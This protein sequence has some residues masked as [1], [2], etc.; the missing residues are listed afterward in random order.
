MNRRASDRRSIPFEHS[1]CVNGNRPRDGFGEPQDDSLI[2]L[3]VL[4]NGGGDLGR[5]RTAASRADAAS[6]DGDLLREEN[7]SYSTALADT[8]QEDLVSV[9]GSQNRGVKQNY[10]VV[11]RDARV[12]A[13]LV[14]LGFVD[15]PVEGPKLASDEY[16]RTLA[17]ALADGIEAFLAQ[18]GTLASSGRDGTDAP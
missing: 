18:G 7:L 12:P 3:A 16:R 8:V 6:I 10:F 17:T 14:E 1:P 11:I 4:E 9:T 5:A 13:V 2:E 15:S